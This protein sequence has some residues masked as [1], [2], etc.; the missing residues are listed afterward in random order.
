LAVAACGSNDSGGSSGSASTGGSSKSGS[1][2]KAD[3]SGKTIGVLSLCEAC[4]GVHRMTT[5]MQDAAKAA[6]WKIQLVDAQGAPDKMA[7][8]MNTLVQSGVDG[9]VVEAVEPALIKQGVQA[10]VNAKIPVVTEDVGHTTTGLLSDVSPDE[11]GNTALLDKE[12]YKLIGSKPGK[13]AAVR[14]MSLSTTAA[15]FNQLSKDAKA[16]DLTIVASHDSVAP[17]F[18]D[19]A[20]TFTNQILTAH[21]DTAAIWSASTG[22]P[23][24]IGAAHAVARLK[25]HAIVVGY[26]GDM[27]A[28]AAIRSNGPFK[29]TIAFPVEEGSW[30]ATDLLLQH[31]AGKTP[32]N[33]EINLPGAVV[34]AANVPAKGQY[35]NKWGDYGAKYAAQWK[36]TYG[37]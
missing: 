19:D 34:T 3:V 17:N 24:A 29:A 33:K 14:Y 16:N 9:I 5:G 28:L 18:A 35:F 6:G 7:A 12:M 1:S 23:A 30:I 22:D 11:A 2:A 26:N 10:A 36:Q 27:D 32:A 13:I 25:S 37:L 4:E 21:P 8:G 15:R 31:F 20:Q